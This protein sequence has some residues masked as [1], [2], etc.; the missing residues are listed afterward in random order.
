MEFVIF[1]AVIGALAWGAWKVRSTFMAETEDELR[2]AWQT[3]LHDPNY[4]RRRQVEETRFLQ[5]SRAR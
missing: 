2:H 3:V 5:H 4:L 1:F